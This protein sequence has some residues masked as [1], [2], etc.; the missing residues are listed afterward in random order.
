MTAAKK[1]APKPGAKDYRPAE[2][3]CRHRNAEKAYDCSSA[4]AKPHW[5]WCQAH[6]DAHRAATKKAPSANPQGKATRDARAERKVVPIA[7]RTPPTP[8]RKVHGRIAALVAVEPTVE[9]VD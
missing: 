8:E 5:T 9:R 1:A 6:V 7:R 3:I 2:G 4:V